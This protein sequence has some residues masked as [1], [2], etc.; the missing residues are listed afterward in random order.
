MV[1]VYIHSTTLSSVDSK[2]VEDR[3]F[4]GL[5]K[6]SEVEDCHTSPLP[7]P[8]S[9]GDPEP[10]HLYSESRITD[11]GFSRHDSLFSFGV[12]SARN[13]VELKS[14]L[15]NSSARLRPGAT[16]LPRQAQT[17]DKSAQPAHA[18]YLERAKSRA[19]IEVDIVLESN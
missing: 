9:G 12:P 1:G 7:E 19:R 5:N 13:A 10:I 18:V 3:S 17:M 16:I 11:S 4:Q 8:V 2:S 6:D 14:L 15:G